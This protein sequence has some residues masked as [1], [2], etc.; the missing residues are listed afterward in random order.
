ML[1]KKVFILTRPNNNKIL[2]DSLSSIGFKSLS[3]PS[4]RIE[5]LDL[6]N[7]PS[8]EIYDFIFFSSSNAVRSYLV[9]INKTYGLI[10]K[11]PLKTSV[12]TVGNATADSF[13]SSGF[14]NIDLLTILNPD[15]SKAKLDSESLWEVLKKQNL[16]GKRFLFVR[17]NKGRD[18]LVNKVS[19]YCEVDLCSVYCRD[20]IQWSQHD[21][22]QLKKISQ[23]TPIV[24]WLFT[25]IES[26]KATIDNIVFLNLS[27]WFNSCKFIVTHERIYDFLLNY[28]IECGVSDKLV[29]KD[30]LPYN[31]SIIKACVDI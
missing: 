6:H 2:S 24:I 17:G 4:L 5:P 10:K 1:S 18:W 26:I 25:S 13:R 19:E 23:E 15:D 27:N 29:I 9:Q 21:S 11:W 3:L 7:V 20:N 14:V 16:Y 12:V 8:P 28:L 22:D 30:C 31:E